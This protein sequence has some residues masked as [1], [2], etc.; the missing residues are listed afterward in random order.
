MKITK[1]NKS[2]RWWLGSKTTWAIK[3]G[4]DWWLVP[5]SEFPE[6]KIN[7]PKRRP[8]KTLIPQRSLSLDWSYLTLIILSS[9]LGISLALNAIYYILK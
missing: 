6:K 5:G 4:D 2:G 8:K 1:K 9:L 7:R 3:N